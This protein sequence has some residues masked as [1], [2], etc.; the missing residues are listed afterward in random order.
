MSTS[1]AREFHGR[2]AELALIRAELERLSDGAQAV[3]IVEGAAGMGKSRLLAEARRSLAASAVDAAQL[4]RDHGR[5]PAPAAALFDEPSH[6][7]S[8]T[9]STLPCQPGNVL[10]AARAV[11]QRAALESL[12]ISSRRPLGRR[13]TFAR[14]ARRCD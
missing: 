2:D 11:A 8:R 6:A 7:R 13:R 12:L 9:L 14:F 5:A 3:V 4:S 10:A 1:P